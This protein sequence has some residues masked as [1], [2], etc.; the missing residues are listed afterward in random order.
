[1]TGD[2]P[3]GYRPRVFRRRKT[4]RA[5]A[6]PELI[7]TLVEGYE[8]FDAEDWPRAG[9]LLAAVA[10]RMDGRDA[11][12]GWFDAALA[13]KFARNWP[14]AYEVG[15]QAVTH[16]RRGT[17]EPA[18]WNLGIAATMLRD[19]DTARDAW[20]GYGLAPFPGTG[21]IDADLGPACIR[22]DIGEVVWAIRICP[23]RARL[24]SVPFDPTRRFG[25]TVLHDGVPKGQRILESGTFPVF[26]E[27]AVFEPS[28]V[29][30]L[31]VLVTGETP[32][33]I[34]ALQQA[35]A[36]RR[37][38]VEI[39]R[40]RVDLCACCSRAGIRQEVKEFAGEQMLYLGAPEDVA[41]HLLH[42]W[43]EQRPEARSWANLHLARTAEG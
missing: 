36:S 37:L 19:W 32:G 4:W 34:R 2:H 21:Q 17:E 18:Y 27:M 7:R 25:E 8:A 39:L 3:A 16:V 43:A 29:G 14:R 30:T 10:P 5:T 6:D 20:I 38:G 24:I 35:F 12:A 15:K 33:D 40:S 26:E 42:S 1:L 41:R 13:Y 28:D 23:T 22:L 31:S 9:D 11:K